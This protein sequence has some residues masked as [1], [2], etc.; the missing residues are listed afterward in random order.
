M[1]SSSSTALAVPDVGDYYGY[2]DFFLGNSEKLR[3]QSIFWR[4]PVRK[5]FVCQIFFCL[6][7]YPEVVERNIFPNASSRGLSIYQELPHLWYGRS[8]IFYEFFYIAYFKC[9][10]VFSSRR[11]TSIS[12]ITPY[13]SAEKT[14]GFRILLLRFKLRPRWQR[15]GFFFVNRALAFFIRQFIFI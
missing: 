15:D 4:S 2:T 11:L 7:L 12:T 9:V 13:R 5:S 10:P 8:T 3:L 1:Y 14:Y 6:P